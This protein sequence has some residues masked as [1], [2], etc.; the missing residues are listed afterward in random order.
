MILRLFLSLL[1]LCQPC[2]AWSA[3][4]YVSSSTGNDANPGDI[5][6][7]KA[8]IA[9]GYA[10]LTDNQAD[11]LLLKRGDTW[12]ITSTITFQKSGASA[13]APMVMGAYGTGAR[14]IIQGDVGFIIGS[15]FAQDQSYLTW[16]HLDIRATGRSIDDDSAG[17]LIAGDG[18]N[19]TVQYCIVRGF[20][21]NIAILPIGDGF[22]LEN[23]TIH[24]NIIIDAWNDSHAQGI[25]A[26]GV[27][28]LVVTENFLDH[29]GWNDPDVGE[30]DDNTYS[31]NAY[32]TGPLGNVTYSGNVST[33][34]SLLGLK[35]Q[36]SGGT[37]TFEHNMWAQN[38][39]VQIGG[40]PDGQDPITLG[41]FRYNT[42]CE[43]RST[44]FGPEGWGTSFTNIAAGTVENNVWCNWLYAGTSGFAIK[45]EDLRGE[46]TGIGVHDTDFLGN[47]IYNT[48]GHAFQQIAPEDDDPVVPN[49]YTGVTFNGN[50][51]QQVQ[52]GN[53][54][55]TMNAYGTAAA[56]N[57]IAYSN[58]R[59]TPDAS[60]RFTK[61]GSTTNFAGWVSA[62]G[63][64]GGSVSAVS[65][66]ANTRTFT[67][68]VTEVLELDDI[69]DY[70]AA[71]L[72]MDDTDWDES[73]LG[74]EMSTWVN[75]GF[76]IGEAAAPVITS[77]ADPDS[78]SINENSTA[79]ITTIVATGTPPPAFT[80][81]GTDNAFFT[82]TD[83][84]N[85]TAT[86][87]FT[88]GRDYESPADDGANN[89]YVVTIEAASSEGADE[90]TLTVT[91]NDVDEALLAKPILVFP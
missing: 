25:I 22:I 65:Y 55:A 74:E 18:G 12:T 21:N 10:L 6:S 63:E 15:H 20:H 46:H 72:A 28:G 57:L 1:L 19:I 68:Y 45:L 66:P 23:I 89:T 80:K 13:M 59:Y 17:F 81:S 29:N 37:H 88:A 86:L 76:G 47:V 64:T 54:S 14:P 53:T 44:G 2:L 27:N 4:Y 11:Q 73:M 56:G 9:A 8:T 60:T 91:V 69:D 70:R 24:R 31:H 16:E 7:P 35:F 87:A 79:V 42:T 85:G 49:L 38:G 36:P 50:D 30:G 90:T 83:L 33:R 39:A 82:L 41:S 52:A 32:L 40:C 62:T 34:A 75:A 78:E 5:G 58:N 71:M 84:A 67:T 26:G 3:T 51:V 77:H 48:S 61:S 43:S